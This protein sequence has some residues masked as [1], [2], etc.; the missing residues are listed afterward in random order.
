MQIKAQ[1]IF[2][3]TYVHCASFALFL[4]SVGRN[5]D[6]GLP[7]PLLFANTN[8]NKVINSQ[9]PSGFLRPTVYLNV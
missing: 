3:C 6:I 8:R 7:H 5:F 9:K 1:K 2:K 4:D